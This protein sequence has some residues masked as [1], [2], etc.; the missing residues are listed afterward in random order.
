MYLTKTYPNHPLLPAFQKAG[1]V[2]FD[3]VKILADLDPIV[4]RH[5]MSYL[6]EREQLRENVL[7]DVNMMKYFIDTE[8][9]LE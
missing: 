2:S 8:R 7:S 5:A 3:I 9:F 1:V 6:S 4:L